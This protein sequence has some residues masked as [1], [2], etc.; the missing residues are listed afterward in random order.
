MPVA[1]MGN[2][3]PVLLSRQFFLGETTPVQSW[4]LP[5]T[6]LAPQERTADARSRS[7]SPWEKTR[8]RF[9]NT[10]KLAPQRTAS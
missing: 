10:K 5:K 1:S 8:Y 9:A 6:A 4:G 2:P 3:T 7:V